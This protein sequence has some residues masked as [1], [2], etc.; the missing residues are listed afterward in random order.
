MPLVQIFA[1]PPEQGKVKTRLIPDLGAVKATEIYRYCLRFTLELL[2]ASQH[3]YQIW[4][5]EESKHAFFG[6]Q[7]CHIQQ[8]DDLGQR[9]YHA[10]NHGLNENAANAVILIGSDCLDMTEAHINQAIES[11]KEHDI[12]LLPTIDGGFA[13]IGCRTIQHDLFT[14]V[15]WSSGHVLQQT[16]VNASKLNY[17]VH[18]LET[19]RDIDTL[20][21]LNHYPELRALIADH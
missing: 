18:L 2:Q 12:V 6:E 13:L 9:M 5:G 17:S 4:L 20:S 7:D 3:D 8:G 10:L 11:L 16:L 1:K 14:D 19:V 21:D 15:E